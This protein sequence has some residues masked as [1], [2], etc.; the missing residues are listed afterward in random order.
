MTAQWTAALFGV[1]TGLCILWLVRRDRLHGL[2]AMW[3]LLIAL[4]V[5]VLGLFPRVV[6]WLGGLFGV[7]YPPTLILLLGLSAVILK[8]LAIDIGFTRRERQTR[9]L[10]QKVAILELELRSLKA[11]RDERVTA[12]T[13]DE[14]A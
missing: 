11:E 13:E 10:L 7:S 2:F 8:L 14:P 6:D 12:A 4:A 5:L 3:W 1:I 9:R